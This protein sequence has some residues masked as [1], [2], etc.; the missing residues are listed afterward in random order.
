VIREA[1]KQLRNV[2]KDMGRPGYV[3]V[4]RQMGKTNLL[5]NAKRELEDTNSALIYIDLSA[6]FDSERECF[7]HI[8][9]TALETRTDV[10]GKCKQPILEARKTSLPPSY[11]EHENELRTLLD[12]ITG[13]LVIILDEIDSL[14][15]TAFSDK[16]FAQIRSVY[17]SRTNYQQFARLCQMP[18]V[19]VRAQ[20]HQLN[21]SAD[22]Y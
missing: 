6:P 3:L 21:R 17:F 12:A 8:I 10:F 20:D 18:Q 15:K 11:K 14:T 7:R 16:I 5:L 4:A 1:D 9:D 2:I 13:K 19:R 22:F